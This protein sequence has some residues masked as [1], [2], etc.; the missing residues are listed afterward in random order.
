MKPDEIN[1]LYQYTSPFSGKCDHCRE[2]GIT[3]FYETPNGEQ[4]CN[5]CTKI[6][7]ES[8][9]ERG[10]SVEV[11]EA[12]ENDP[13]QSSSR[14]DTDGSETE[15]QEIVTKVV[16]TQYRGRV[17]PTVVTFEYERINWAAVDE[18]DII[19]DDQLVVYGSRP[20]AYD[21]ISA[22]EFDAA[23][24]YFDSSISEANVVF[25]TDD[26]P[27]VYE[28]VPEQVDEK[29]L[30][31][32]VLRVLANQSRAGIIDGLQPKE[33]IAPPIDQLYEHLE[34]HDDIEAFDITEQ[35]EELVCKVVLKRN[36]NP[37]AIFEEIR[38]VDGIQYL[39]PDVVE[40]VSEI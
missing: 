10:L 31:G 22:A 28:F 25:L 6:I 29:T 17:N 14:D 13:D 9:R 4:L 24:A 36:R 2:R 16:Q 1:T 20:G 8:F 34:H 18:T 21:E 7:F 35:E 19:G 15:L 23:R 3:I 5:D 11:I 30:A 33:E 38:T 40:V 37:D 12:L 32:E 27:Y 39:K 26:G